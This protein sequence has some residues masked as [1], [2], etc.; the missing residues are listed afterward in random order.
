MADSQGSSESENR[1]GKREREREQ[2]KGEIARFEFVHT[3][4]DLNDVLCITDTWE[5][6]KKKKK[7][8]LEDSDGWCIIDVDI[9]YV[10]SQY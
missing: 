10:V 4:S 5:E 9:V 8:I 3:V 1:D 2:G 7:C 6:Y